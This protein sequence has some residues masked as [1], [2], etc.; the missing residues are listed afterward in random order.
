MND[1]LILCSDHIK[2]DF[3]LQNAINYCIS[4]NLPLEVHKPHFKELFKLK[5][6]FPIVTIH[7][8]WRDFSLCTNNQSYF[9]KSLAYLKK[10]IKFIHN[11]NIT[12]I[13]IHPE[14]YPVDLEKKVRIRNIIRAFRELSKSCE[15]ESDKR[16]KILI[17][18]MPTAAVYPP[19]ELPDYYI[20]ERL[21]DLIPILDISK[22][23]EFLFDLGHFLCSYNY[24][25]EE[26]L[27]ILKKLWKKLTYIH[28]HDNNGEINNHEPLS[29]S[30]SI[31]ILQLI[32]NNCHPKYS[33]EISPSINGLKNTIN[34]IKQIMNG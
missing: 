4:H 28:V 20:G 31:K 10:L 16:C 5:K 27:E 1:R 11:K 21:E 2:K 34:E 14:G 32:E 24:Y 23:I 19:S 26:Q 15:S 13:I 25:G 33:F 8:H 29:R 9:T 18:N 17:E 3:N 6:T 7:P 30:S 12:Y 22:N